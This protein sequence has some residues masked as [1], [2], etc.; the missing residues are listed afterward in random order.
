EAARSTVRS[1]RV[2]RRGPR[3]RRG[4]PA[5]PPHGDRWI[6]REGLAVTRS[7][8]PLRG[9]DGRRGLLGELPSSLVHLRRLGDR[10]LPELGDSEAL[11]LIPP[12]LPLLWSP[13]L[14]WAWA[15]RSRR[16]ASI[17]SRS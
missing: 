9:D 11:S 6:H 4:V 13:A 14:R 3:E 1:P 2:P 17:W 8:D 15:A 16:T 12:P 5:D 7:E 10:P